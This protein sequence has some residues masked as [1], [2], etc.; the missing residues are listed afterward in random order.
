MLRSLIH[1][2]LRQLSYLAVPLNSW[3]SIE[4]I[5]GHLTKWSA[6]AMANKG[7]HRSSQFAKM[8]VLWHI[9]TSCCYSWFHTVKEYQN[10]WSIHKRLKIQFLLHIWPSKITE[11]QMRIMIAQLKRYPSVA[12][13][14]S[15]KEL[16]DE[17]RLDLHFISHNAIMKMALKCSYLSTVQT[18]SLVTSPSECTEPVILLD[19]VSER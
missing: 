15:H 14:W 7:Q 18:T 8:H 12:R 17:Q 16:G 3:L 5:L 6:L 10:N 19:R 9:S 13:N 4:F 1:A 11:W 2:F